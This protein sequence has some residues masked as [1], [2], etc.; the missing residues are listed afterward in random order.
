VVQAE[1]TSGEVVKRAA[2][3][4]TESNANV[5]VMLNHT[6]KYIPDWLHQEL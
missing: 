1:K 6:R 3:I 5:A 4:L 2:K